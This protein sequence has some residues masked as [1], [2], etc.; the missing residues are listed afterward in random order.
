MHK[1]K[2]RIIVICFAL[3]L[4]FSLVFIKNK[5]TN[6]NI[7]QVYVLNKEKERGEK[8]NIED[9]NKINVNKSSFNFDSVENVDDIVAK[10]TLKCG[11]ILNK[12]QIVKESEFI[13]VSSQDKERII[14]KLSDLDTNSSSIFEKNSVVNIYYTGRT[15]QLENVIKDI[16]TIMIKSSSISDGYT[17]IALLKNVII[18]NIYDNNGKKIQEKNSSNIIDSIEI[19]VDSNMAAIIENLKNYGK[20]SI[21]IKR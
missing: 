9:V 20:F 7:T 8:I 18:I 10:E 15:S 6:L 2:K 17:T 11:Q 3:I 19:E 14:I 21:T 5:M 16:Q 13:Q 4:Y 12:E 1:Y